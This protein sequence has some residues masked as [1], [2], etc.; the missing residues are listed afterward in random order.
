[1]SETKPKFSAGSNLRVLLVGA[2]GVFGRRLAGQLMREDGVSLILAG[3][4]IERLKR[5]RAGLGGGGEVT[6][7]DRETASSADLRSIGA[8]VVI[9]AAGPFQF[10]GM[11][12]IPAAIGAGCD[13][14]DLADC[15]RFV[16]NVGRFDSD[17]REAGIAVLSG[18][19][20]TP[21]LTHAVVDQMVREWREVTAVRIV[22]CPGNRVPRGLS[23]VRAV[24]SYA[25]KPVRVFRCGKWVVE[26]G[27]GRA[28][29]VE[30]PGLGSRLASI[31]ETPDLDLLVERYQPRKTAEFLAGLELSVLHRALAVAGLAVRMGLISSLE[32]IA[33]PAR[34]AA[35]LLERF[36]TDEGGMLVEVSGRDGAGTLQEAR[37]SLIA[38]SG[39]GPI[40]P[41][42]PALA[43]V[44]KI[45]DGRLTF[46]GAK[47]C[48]G[49]LSLEDFSSDFHRL[50]ITTDMHLTGIN[51]PDTT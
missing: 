48:V 20:T 24:L 46:K 12:L 15:R 5:L 22:V 3:R 47:A 44:R 13:Y 49:L 1:M 50:G 35:A 37:W 33:R 10:G 11:S 40:I 6:C 27:W 34:F 18:A 25:G 16:G 45:R 43:L 32:R 51:S 36:G 14:I 9:D 30:L 23:V 39:L 7:L 17:A 31:C 41:T 2:T 21:A 28:R 42:L 26:P 19:S 29:S 4:D 8:N 38:R